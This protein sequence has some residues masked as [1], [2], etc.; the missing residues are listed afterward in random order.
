MKGDAGRALAD[1]LEKFCDTIVSVDDIIN[2]NYSN[3]HSPNR[4]DK[5]SSPRKKHKY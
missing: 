4:M 5:S 2:K 3:K 1:R